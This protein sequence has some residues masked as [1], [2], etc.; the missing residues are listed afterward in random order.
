MTGIC[1]EVCGRYTSARS[2]VPSRIRAGTSS[3][4]VT[5][6]GPRPADGGHGPAPAPAGDEPPAPSP[7]HALN[8]KAAVQINAAAR[9][10]SRRTRTTLRAEQARPFAGTQARI[11]V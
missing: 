8:T 6:H 3:C 2:V 11:E 9:T 10:A 4:F 1:S 5:A 7:P